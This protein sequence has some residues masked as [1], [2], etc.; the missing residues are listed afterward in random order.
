MAD[1]RLP[2]QLR[3]TR[4]WY[5]RQARWHESR[6]ADPR[7]RYRDW[8]L[9]QAA[10]YRATIPRFM[11]RYHEIGRYCTLTIYSYTESMRRMCD[12]RWRNG[13]DVINCPSCFD[14]WIG[15][16]ESCRHLYLDPSEWSR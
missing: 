10:D 5:L 3:Y 1:L 9:A 16:C 12:S 15:H 4:A 7:T 11:A 13:L 14:A 6:A 8:H 2:W